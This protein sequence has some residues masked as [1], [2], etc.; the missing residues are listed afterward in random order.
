[1]RAP[2]LSPLPVLVPYL[3]HWVANGDHPLRAAAAE[4]PLERAG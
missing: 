1:M 4:Q 3:C 2:L